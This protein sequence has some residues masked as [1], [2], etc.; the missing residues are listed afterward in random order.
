MVEFLNDAH[1][2]C[3]AISNAVPKL[4]EL[5]LS[6]TP[7]DVL[8]AIEFFKT[9]YLFNIKGTENG[10]RLMLRLLYVNT[11]QDKNDKAEA[12]MR[13]YYQI[14]FITDARGRAHHSKVVGNLCSFLRNI[15]TSEYI[16]FELMIKHWVDS[17]DIDANIITVLYE[18]FTLKLDGTT[19]D[20]ARC[21]LELLILI[22]K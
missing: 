19:P 17:N 15:S 18:R 9:G 4:E 5:L 22:S 20:Y 13:S 7:S 8:E 16:A 6:T 2:F 1:A 10:M 3:V 14:L 21:C 11:G 12:V